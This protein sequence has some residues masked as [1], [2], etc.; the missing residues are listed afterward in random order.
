MADVYPNGYAF[1]IENRSRWQK[2]IE[3]D[4]LLAMVEGGRTYEQVVERAAAQHGFVRVVDLDELGI[5]QVYMRRLAAGGRAEHRGHGL[6]RLHALPVTPLDEFHEAVLW[7]GDG[8]AIGGEAA[9]ALWE[10]ADV[11]PRRI[12]VVVPPGRRVDRRKGADRYRFHTEKLTAKDIDFIEGIPVAR[13]EVA[14]REAIDDG[15]EGTLV[16]QA[17][18]TAARRNLLKDLAEARLRVALADRSAKPA[19]RAAR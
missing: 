17:I 16:E 4:T 6:Y 9:L 10:L 19:G 5:D 2:R 14:I 13:P 18:T 8:A 7:A 15:T 12:E 3:S 1:A 11:N